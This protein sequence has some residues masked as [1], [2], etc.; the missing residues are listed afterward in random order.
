M[1]WA[2]AG[3]FTHA[4]R[5]QMRA[6]KTVHMFVEIH[7]L[8]TIELIG[9]CLDHLF[10]AR[11][12]RFNAWRIPFNVCTRS[13]FVLTTSFDC[14]AR[15]FPVVYVLDLM[16]AHRADPDLCPIHVGVSVWVVDCAFMSM[17]R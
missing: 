14:T 15:H 16:M 10:L 17:G 13:L 11:L 12:D 7:H 2:S 1:M 4:L 6:S 5:F 8:E 3:D 9:H